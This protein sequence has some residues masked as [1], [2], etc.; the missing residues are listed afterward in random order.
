MSSERLSK[1][2]HVIERGIKAGGY[3]GASVVVGRRG[4]AVWE[5]GFGQLGWNASD[6]EVT[7]GTIYDI[8]SLTK[9]V[10]TTTAV[11]LLYDEDKIQLDEPVKTYLPEFSGGN[12]DLVTVRMLLEHRSGLPPG[13]D[14][15][16]MHGTA[17]DARNAV[18]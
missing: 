13:R 18:I 1:I 5:K 8:A 9:V 7:P 2:D 12:K 11:M 6:P 4:A 3:P 14:L 10:G 16:R 17:A 15:W